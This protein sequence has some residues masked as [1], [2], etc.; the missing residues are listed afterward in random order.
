[1]QFSK[2]DSTFLHTNKFFKNFKTA[3]NYQIVIK[4]SLFSII[5]YG[6]LFFYIVTFLHSFLLFFSIHNIL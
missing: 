3:K 1:M 6:N 5:T 2:I 4:N